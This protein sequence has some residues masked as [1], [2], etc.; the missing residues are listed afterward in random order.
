MRPAPV[1]GPQRN[2]DAPQVVNLGGIFAYRGG[3]AAVFVP[4]VANWNHEFESATGMVGD[5]IR[6]IA[7]STMLISRARAPKRTGKMAMSILA[8]PLG[9]TEWQVQANTDY[10][11][12]VH[13]GTKAH[14]IKPKFPGY[15][16]KFDWPKAGLFPARFWHVKHPGTKAQPFLVDA[17]KT[18][19]AHYTS[20]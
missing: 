6:K 17:M 7:T 5:H 13:Q 15:P 8:F 3:V 2:D 1:S 16:L 11:F 19:L 18:A 4:N 12:F 10:S 20:R 14:I 9:G